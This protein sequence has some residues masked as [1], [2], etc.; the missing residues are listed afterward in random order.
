M[1][2]IELKSYA[3]INLSLNILS[4]ED[5]GMHSIDTIVTNIDIYDTIK[6][7]KR[8]D[9]K[10]NISYTNIKHTIQNDTTKKMALLLQQEYNTGGVDIQI[11]KQI[12][13]HAGLGGSSADA[14]GTAI[15]LQRLFNINTIPLPLLL[16]VGSDVPYMFEGGTKRIRG[17]GDI[18]ESI[19]DINAYFAIVI[20]PGGVSTA[21]AYTLYDTIGGESCDIPNIIN[22]LT[23]D[24]TI[25]LCNSLQRAAIALNNNIQVGLN[26]LK[27]AGFC[28]RVMSGSGSAVLGMMYD[29][30]QFY[31]AV[32]I[33]KNILPTNYRL[34]INKKGRKNDKKNL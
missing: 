2:K 32:N 20:C 26:L 8:L 15:C 9:D 23:R 30:E 31:Y 14:A 27:Q 17:K 24:K 34:H 16:K 22:A 10:I 33:L 25:G 7:K 29:K 11:E 6:A 5:C 18:I 12:P 4:K 13:F 28:Q 3:K 19:D 21:Q 1:D